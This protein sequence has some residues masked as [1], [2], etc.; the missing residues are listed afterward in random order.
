MR[1]RVFAEGQ[2]HAR[3]LPKGMKA[4]A[5]PK[6]LRRMLRGILPEGGRN[7]HLERSPKILSQ[8]KMEVDSHSSRVNTGTAEKIQDQGRKM[9]V[10][11][12]AAIRSR[13]S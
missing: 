4:K 11:S 1:E 2:R 9:G 3:V 13:R 7:N 6:F 10:R 8:A 12:G 5:E